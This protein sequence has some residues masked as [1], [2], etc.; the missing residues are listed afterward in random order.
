MIDMKLW[1]LLFVASLKVFARTIRLFYNVDDIL[2]ERNTTDCKLETRTNRH[3]PNRLTQCCTQ[4]K[5][6]GIK[7]LCV[8]YLHD[9]VGFICK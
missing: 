5:S 9:N 3:R 4:F 8:L 7:I 2:G 6:P 1:V